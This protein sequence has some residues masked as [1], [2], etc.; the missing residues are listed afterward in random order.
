MYGPAT[1]AVQALLD[2]ADTLDAATLTELEALLDLIA[3]PAGGQH[4]SRRHAAWRRLYAA[5]ATHDLEAELQALWDYF[6]RTSWPGDYAR[7]VALDAAAATMLRPVTALGPF[8][9]TDHDT[10]MAPWRAA[11]H[12]CTRSRLFLLM[13]S[14]DRPAA[15]LWA[16]ADAVLAPS[17]LDP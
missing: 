5:I 11:V 6:T 13:A 17:T 9:R 15:R 7:R 8:T 14:S 12:R 2:R 16:L 3:T 1:H 4:K 10:L